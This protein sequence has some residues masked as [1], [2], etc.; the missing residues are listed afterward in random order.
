[1]LSADPVVQSVVL[2]SYAAT[3]PGRHNRYDF[4]DNETCGRDLSNDFD[5]DIKSLGATIVKRDDT[6]DY[7]PEKFQ[8]LLTGVAS[9]HPDAVFYGGVAANGS[10]VLWSAMQAAGLSSVTYL[11]GDGTVDPQLFKATRA[12]GGQ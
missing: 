9:L 5:K 1:R 7:T 3:N 6:T 11:S 2:S 10:G 4:S 12:A 8:S